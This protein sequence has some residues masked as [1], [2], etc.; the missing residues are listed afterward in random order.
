MK[1][2]FMPYYINGDTIRDA[3]KIAINRFE[4]IEINATREDTTIQA[5]LPLSELTCGKIIQGS[6]T[7]TLSKSSQRKSIDEIETSLI[8]I[9]V[10]L[11]TLLHRNNV[12][13]TL[14]TDSNLTTISPGDIVEVQCITEKSDSTLELLRNTLELMEFQQVTS[15]V[16]NTA[17]IN[18]INRNIKALMED[19]VLKYPT[20]FT[21]DSDTSV[22]TSVCSKHSSMD[23][24]CYI[25][26]P[27]TIVG[28]ISNYESSPSNP[29]IIDS[30]PLV[31][32]LLWDFINSNDK[33]KDFISHLNYNNEFPKDKKILE[34]V[35]FVIYV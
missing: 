26:R 31:S 7:V 29:N 2:V 10:N 12:I 16:D 28:E 14:D 19:K 3:Y 22:I 25:G 27:C 5:T 34:I 20:T 13:K 11:E 24:E 21:F 30:N 23:L 17:M 4:N 35:P 9:F 1:N 6:A 32:K 8:N 15:N 33:Y 18:W